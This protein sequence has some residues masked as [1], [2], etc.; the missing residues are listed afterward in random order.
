MKLLRGKASP[1]LD[2]CIS[3]R[4]TRLPTPVR[5]TDS[6]SALWCGSSSRALHDLKLFLQVTQ[7]TCRKVEIVDRPW[8]RTEKICMHVFIFGVLEDITLEVEG[9]IVQY[10]VCWYLLCKMLARCFFFFAGKMFNCVIVIENSIPL[11]TLSSIMI[12]K[13]S[14]Q[15]GHHCLNFCFFINFIVF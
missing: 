6:S 10:F 1:H 14:A 12:S 13:R 2:Y 3:V 4:V 9:E 15:S 8:S 11:S 7:V 5:K